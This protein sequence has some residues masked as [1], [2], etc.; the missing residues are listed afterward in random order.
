LQYLWDLLPTDVKTLEVSKS[1]D[2]EIVALWREE[3]KLKENVK[4]AKGYDKH[5]QKRR[6]SAFQRR[7]PKL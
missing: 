2:Q 4:K 1:R 6:L 7:R 3:K 5:R